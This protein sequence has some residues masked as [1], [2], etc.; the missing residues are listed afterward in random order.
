MLSDPQTITVNAVAQVMPRIINESLHS[1]YVLSDG[2]YSLD[3][4]HRSKRV[5]K[6]IRVVSL[7][8]F[9]HRKVVTDPLT[10]VNDYDNALWSVQLDRPEVGFTNTELINDVTGLKTWLDSTMIGKLIGKES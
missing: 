8:A 1:Q 2:T 3:I 10:S 7:V 6:K 5:D 9:N 4:R